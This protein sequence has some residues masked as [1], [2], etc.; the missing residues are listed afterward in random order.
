MTARGTTSL[1]N[2]FGA[3]SVRAPRETVIRPS[4]SA[5]F[6]IQHPPGTTFGYS[7]RWGRGTRPCVRFRSHSIHGGAERAVMMCVLQRAAIVEPRPQG[8]VLWKERV[9][10]QVITWEDVFVVIDDGGG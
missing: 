3:P 2:R 9:H 6:F 7:N 1:T 8:S 4:R 10:I 5:A